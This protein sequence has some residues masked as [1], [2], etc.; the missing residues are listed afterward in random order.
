MNDKHQ[1]RFQAQRCLECGLGPTMNLYLF[2]GALGI[3]LWSQCRVD[4]TFPGWFIMGL[5]STEPHTRPGDTKSR[6]SP[7]AAAQ[8]PRSGEEPEIGQAAR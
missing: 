4:F 1:A 3:P 7:G 2:T 8:G 6:T 5:P